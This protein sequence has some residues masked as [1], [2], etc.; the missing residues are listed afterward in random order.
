MNQ[1][2][3]GRIGEIIRLHNGILNSFKKTLA[4][5]IKI[6]ELLTDQKGN[7]K[8]GEFMA[9]VNENLPFT[10]RTARNYM[11]VYKERDG[12]KTETVSDLSEAYHRLVQMQEYVTKRLE[13]QERNEVARQRIEYA[14][15]HPEEIERETPVGTVRYEKCGAG[16]D[17]KITI[18][19]YMAG[20]PMTGCEC[21]D[22]EYKRLEK[23]Q[24]PFQLHCLTHDAV[25][26]IENAIRKLKNICKKYDSLNKDDYYLSWSDGVQPMF[27]PL[28][29][30]IDELGKV[31]MK[32]QTK[33]K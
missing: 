14:R 18:D 1:L 20:L 28:F 4:D 5:A 23:G 25:L 29:K 15:D 8:H 3:K 24:G 12:L 27:P 31:I 30:A 22:P 6:G 10:D 21:I 7:L 13:H 33:F 17:C 16:W 2:E 11:R 9:W 26:S 32:I 19:G